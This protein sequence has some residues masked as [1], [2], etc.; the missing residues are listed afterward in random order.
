MVLV[1]EMD[2]EMDVTAA[3][4][5]EIRLRGLTSIPK[6]VFFIVAYHVIIAI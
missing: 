4:Q 5:L 6:K 3:I 1:L 2:T